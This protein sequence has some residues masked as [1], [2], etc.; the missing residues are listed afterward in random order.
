MKT[1]AALGVLAMLAW[2][3]PVVAQGPS[4]DEVIAQIND[5]IFNARFDEAV[6]LSQTVL[7]RSELSAAQRNATLEA[8]AT[9]QLANRHERE[10]QATLRQL[11]ARDPGHRMADPD[12]S[13]VIVSAFA[14]AR[15]ANPDLVP[16]RIEHQP[17]SLSRRESPQI[18][19]RLAEG[20]DAVAEVRVSYRVEG[21]DEGRIVLTPGPNGAYVG[22]IPLGGAASAPTRVSYQITAFAPSMTR[23]AVLGTEREPLVLT[24][25]P[26]DAI[27]RAAD[28]FPDGERPPALG[29]ETTADDG[30]D[31]GGGGSVLE[32]WWF[33]TL[34]AVLVIGGGVTAGV[35]IAT[36][37]GPE[38]GTLGSARLMLLSF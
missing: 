37:G 33:W 13:P 22:R 17:P 24:V 15:E 8:M 25:P 28:P 14:R 12:A 36:Q 27:A 31:S 4:P 23:L 35:L 20:A 34:L 32:E 9:A 30:S 19:A 38:E 5:L 18:V 11:Y 1:R 7:D 10:A 16:V 2:A 3:A 26:G 21:A 29:D 6:E